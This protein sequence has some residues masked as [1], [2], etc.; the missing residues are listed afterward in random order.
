MAKTLDLELYRGVIVDNAYWMVGV[1]ELRPYH[2][3]GY[4]EW[5]VYRG[6]QERRS[7]VDPVIINPPPRVTITHDNYV[8]YFSPD[9]LNREG[10]N[11]QEAAYR[12]CA[13]QLEPHG[14]KALFEN[15]S[16][17]LTSEVDS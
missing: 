10:C 2:E 5:W 16:D 12:M 11:V 7:G 9:A 17:Q 13:E 6:E 4:V 15:A 1:V 3:T 14:L 8:R